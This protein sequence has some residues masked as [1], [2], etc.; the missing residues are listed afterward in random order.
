MA[1]QCSSLENCSNQVTVLQTSYET[2]LTI[3]KCLRSVDDEKSK[4][5]LLDNHFQPLQWEYQEVSLSLSR[6]LNILLSSILVLVFM[7]EP[8]QHGKGFLSS[9]PVTL[10]PKWFY[11]RNTGH[12]YQSHYHLIFLRI[13]VGEE[14]HCTLFLKSRKIWAT[15]LLVRNHIICT[16]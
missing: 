7:Q 5:S 11:N 9:L 2:E 3:I 1:R 10:I 6:T 4:V 12:L 13:V 14:L 15:F 8:I 16:S